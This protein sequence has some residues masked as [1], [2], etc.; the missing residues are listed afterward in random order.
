VG[1][2]PSQ[3]YK[4]EVEERADELEVGGENSIRWGV[5]LLTSSLSMLGCLSE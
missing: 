1:V 2:S 3:Q 5:D 4:D